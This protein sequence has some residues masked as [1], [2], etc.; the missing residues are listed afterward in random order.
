M[1]VFETL[2]HPDRRAI[3]QLLAREDRR[4]G[5]IAAA[6]PHVSR[7]A[8][9]WQL[10]ALRESGL[11]QVRTEGR[12]RVYALDPS[13]LDAVDAWTQEQRALWDARLEAIK[14]MAETP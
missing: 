8:I 11:V 12:A 14:R 7:P 5:E 3:L 6:F 4:A 9:S 10:R 2:A 1:D 13:G